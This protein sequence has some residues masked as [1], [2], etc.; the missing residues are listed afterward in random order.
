MCSR[1]GRLLLAVGLGIETQRSKKARV[2]EVPSSEGRVPAFLANKPVAIDEDPAPF[3][4]GLGPS[5]DGH[6][7][8]RFQGHY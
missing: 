2:E 7:R 4:V 1:R 6:G 5:E 8:W 3:E